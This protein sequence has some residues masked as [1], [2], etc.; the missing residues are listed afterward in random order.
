M[1]P[2][3]MKMPNTDHV[4]GEAKKMEGRVKDAAGAATD[5]PKLQ[6]KGKKDKLEGEARKA[7]GDLKDAMKPKKG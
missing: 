2:M 4:K 5:N 1:F 6:A 7:K 3:E